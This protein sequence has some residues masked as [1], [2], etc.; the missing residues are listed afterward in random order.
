MIETMEAICLTSAK[1]VMQSAKKEV[2]KTQN[3][4]IR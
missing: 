2:I 3:S 1:S 4:V